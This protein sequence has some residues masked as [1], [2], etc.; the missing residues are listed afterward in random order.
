MIE[1]KEL[2]KKAVEVRKRTV[3]IVHK[4]SG[5]H[6]GGSLSS[7]DI[8]VALHFGVMNINPENPG[9]GGRD[10]FIMSKGHSVESYYSTLEKRGFI[11]HEIVDTYGKFNSLLAGHPTRKVPGIEL[12]SGALGHGLS[13]GVGLALAAKRSGES[14][15]TYVLMGDGEHGEGSI[16]EAA[17]SAGHYKLNNLVAIIDRNQLQISGR[18]EDVCAV[19]DLEGKYRACGWNVIHCDGHNMSELLKSFQEAAAIIEKPT[20]VIAHTV[21]GKGISFMEDKVKWHHKVPTNEQVEQA[22]EE[23]NK[24]MEDIDNA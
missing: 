21:K 14:Y 1:V 12:N 18:T 15:R 22:F 5:G 11:S 3:D 19:D 20:F 24:R 17:A 13:V 7:V 10:R 16:M 23:L 8:L 2:E 6:I 4:A 9:M